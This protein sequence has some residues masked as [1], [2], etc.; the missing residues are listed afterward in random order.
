[1]GTKPRKKIRWVG[2]TF[3]VGDKVFIGNVDRWFSRHSGKI[4]ALHTLDHLGDYNP[5][6][7]IRLQDG[8]YAAVALKDLVNFSEDFRI[9]FRRKQETC[10]ARGHDYYFSALGGVC[11]TCGYDRV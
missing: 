5:Y 7:I 4:L 8:K 9:G 6:A 11:R 1:M 3:Q 2:F 10:G